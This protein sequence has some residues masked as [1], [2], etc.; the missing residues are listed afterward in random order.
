ML[1]KVDIDR[2]EQDM[3][4]LDGKRFV[5]DCEVSR[6]GS[7]IAYNAT[8]TRKPSDLFIWNSADGRE[9]RLTAFNDAW[10]KEH[11]LSDY[12]EVMYTAPDGTELQGWYLHPKDH[13]PSK[14]YPMAVEIHGGPQVMWGLSFFHEFQMLASHGYFVFLCNPRGSSGYGRQFQEIRKNGGY[15]DA[16]DILQGMDEVLKRETSIDG[17]R[18]VVTGGSYGGFLSGWIVTHSDRFKAVVSQRGVY[19]ELNMF[20]SGDIPESVEWYFNGVPRV[21]TLQDVWDHSPAAHA[22][23]VTTPLMILHS[24]LDYRVPVSQAETFF[25]HLRRQGK[26]E[27]VMVRYPG[28]G[29]ELSRSGRPLH[30]VDRLYKIMGW[31]DLHINRSEDELGK[32]VDAWLNNGWKV[33]GGAFARTYRTGNYQIGGALLRDYLSAAERYGVQPVFTLESDSLKVVLKGLTW[34]NMKFVLRIER[35]LVDFA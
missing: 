23:N 2:P 35:L 21:E 7:M 22:K 1:R 11:Y 5:T 33:S 16:P 4:V 31:F 14:S 20:G 12:T 17:E 19:D 18:L 15:T 25:A 6:D 9:T 32:A 13:D 34:V 3:T 10:E 28:E 26:K 8:T 29:H 27:T 30:R 24:E